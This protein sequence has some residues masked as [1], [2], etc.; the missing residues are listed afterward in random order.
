M[1]TKKQIDA[2]RRNARRST[3]PKSAEGKALVAANATRT[4]LYATRHL[5]LASLG[6]TAEDYDAHVAATT[7]G[8]APV[9]PL[10]QQIATTI[11]SLAWRL[12]RI[13]Q[14]EAAASQPSKDLPAHPDDIKPL[15]GN[16]AHLPTTPG[17]PDHLASVRG[18]LQGSANRRERIL[19][20]TQLLRRHNSQQ[21]NQKLDVLR[22]HL[23]LEAANLA[24]GWDWLERDAWTNLA[25]EQV[26]SPEENH[27]PRWTIPL[28]LQTFERAAA[29]QGM[30]L[31]VLLP[32]VRYHLKELLAEQD[33]RLEELREEERQLVEV[34][35]RHRQRAEV[36]AMYSTENAIVNIQKAEQHL[37]R[38]LER[39]LAMLE[40]MQGRRRQ[41][42]QPIAA[43][44]FDPLRL[45]SRPAERPTFGFVFEPTNFPLPYPPP[46]PQIPAI[47]STD[48][49]SPA[50]AIGPDT[51]KVDS[52]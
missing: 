52:R 41:A 9:G 15:T 48:M 45:S 25:R 36:V 6:E 3:G 24:F 30:T 16:R 12:R 29:T 11:A 19:D 14:Y 42:A 51:P 8:L 5:T 39:N 28:L 34:L 44:P 33:A 4:G 7:A 46:L 18:K 35:L 21:G 20:V 2:N 23:L 32:K 38:Q 37:T 26:E 1:A 13:P 22:A 47:P 31:D 43:P 49:P 40:T 27:A 10:E 50:A 17:T